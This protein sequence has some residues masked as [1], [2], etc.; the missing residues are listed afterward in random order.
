MNNDKQPKIRRAP[1]L[2][3]AV[4]DL[5]NSPSENEGN[6]LDAPVTT[7]TLLMVMAHAIRQLR[8]GQHYNPTVQ[9]NYVYLCEEILNIEGDHDTPQWEKLEKEIF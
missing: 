8:Y 6:V 5:P 7:R 4:L 1:K 9:E 3:R 2:K